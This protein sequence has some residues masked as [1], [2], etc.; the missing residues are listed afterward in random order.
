[1]QKQNWNKIWQKKKPYT[2]KQ[3][4]QLLQ[5]VSTGLQVNS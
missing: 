4:T 1:M 5:T 2:N 3:N